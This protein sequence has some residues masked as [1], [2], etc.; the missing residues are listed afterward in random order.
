[1]LQF[2]FSHSQVMTFDETDLSFLNDFF[3][4]IKQRK[5]ER[6]EFQGNTPPYG[7]KKDP[8]KRKT[9]EKLILD[10]RVNFVCKADYTESKDVYKVVTTILQKMKRDYDFECLQNKHLADAQKHLK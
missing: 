10:N 7:Y 1:M 4:G 6:G 8:N 2:F 5:I 9:A 3:K